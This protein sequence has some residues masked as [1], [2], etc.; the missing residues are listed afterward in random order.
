M[1]DNS[2]TDYKKLHFIHDCYLPV[3]T[4][5]V[6]SVFDIKLKLDDDNFEKIQEL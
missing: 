4:K 5:K 1:N 2:E 6:R 3:S